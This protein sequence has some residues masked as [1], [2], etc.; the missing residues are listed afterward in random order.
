MH[1]GNYAAT[2]PKL[3][4]DLLTKY[5]KRQTPNTAQSSHGDQSSRQNH[6][7]N[8]TPPQCHQLQQWMLFQ[9]QITRLHYN[10]KGHYSIMEFHINFCRVLQHCCDYNNKCQRKY[11][12]VGDIRLVILHSLPTGSLL[13]Q[14]RRYIKFPS[15]FII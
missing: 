5:R 4:K 15:C 13:T 10:C 12:H 11:V 14:T 6:S 1:L 8:P 3:L 9:F 7:I 2:R